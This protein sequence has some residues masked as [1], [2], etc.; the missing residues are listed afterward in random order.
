MDSRIDKNYRAEIGR[1]VAELRAKRGLSTRQ[2]AELCGIDPSNV[3]KIERGKYNV[4]VDILGRVCEALGARMRIVEAYDVKGIEELSPGIHA[5]E[6]VQGDSPRKR[7][8]RGYYP[9]GY[10]PQE[11]DVVVFDDDVV[12]VFA[13][14]VTAKDGRQSYYIQYGVNTDITF[15]DGCETVLGYSPEW[16]KFHISTPVRPA[17]EEEKLF[18]RYAFAQTKASRTDGSK[19]YDWA[20]FLDYCKTI[21]DNENIQ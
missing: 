15:P 6:Y 10:T 9:A 8:G 21:R 5:Y 4:S 11:G 19:V 12:A 1:Q 18:L 14:I 16:L 20:D 2:L 17:T 3:S 13:G 7:L